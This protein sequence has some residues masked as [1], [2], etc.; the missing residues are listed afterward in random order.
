MICNFES[1]FEEDGLGG[2]VYRLR[3]K[4]RPIPVG[5]GERRRFVNQYAWRISLIWGAM[6][7][8]LN[9]FFVTFYWKV[10]TTP[11]TVLPSKVIFSDPFLYEGFILIGLPATTL[12]YWLGEAPARALKDRASIDPEPT[13]DE[14]RAIGFRKITYGK[15]TLV[16]LLALYWPIASPGHNFLEH[17]ADPWT[18]VSALVMLVVA[19]QAFRKWSFERRHPQTL[20]S[21]E[22]HIIDPEPSHR[23]VK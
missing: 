15:L 4:G 19:V 12:M 13:P 21:S 5:A 8:A 9:I 10:M 18:L 17:G 23:G 1:Q 3:G 7:I 16:A 20:R 6:F 14:K 2:Y 11:S 22:R